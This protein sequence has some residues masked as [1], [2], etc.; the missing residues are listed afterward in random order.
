MKAIT[1]PSPISPLSMCRMSDENWISAM[2][3]YSRQRPRLPQD[4]HKGD[5]FTLATELVWEAQ[6]NKPRF[7]ALAIRMP[8]SLDS[9]YFDAILDGLAETHGTLSED[10]KANA[11]A[12]GALDT[13]TIL[14]VIRR[15][16]NLPGRPCGRAIGF[17]F[18]HLAERP[19]PDEAVDILTHYALK[20]PHPDEELW[21]TPASDGRPYYS[22]SPELAGLNCV[23]GGAADALSSLLFHKLGLW[24]NVRE[25]VEILVVDQ[26]LAVRAMVVECL[27]ARMN[28]DRDEAIQ[29]FLKL[30]EG[31]GAILGGHSIENFLHHAVF[32]HYSR[33]RTVLLEMVT[34]T[35]ENAR[36]TAGRQIAVAA[37]HNKQAEQDLE[38]ALAGDEHCRAAV[39][40]V[41]ATNFGHEAVRDVCRQRLLPF[42]DDESKKVQN[43][44]KMCFRSLSSE[45]LSEERNLINSFI[46][47]RAFRGGFDQL[48]FALEHSTALLPDV[49]CAIPERLIAQHLAE[50]PNEPLEQHYFVSSLPELVI[51]VYE[52]ARDPGI[53]TRCLN[54]IDAMIELGLSS[55]ESELEKVER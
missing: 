22:G 43:A 33:V 28:Q 2:V 54:V 45:Q 46:K 9:C 12:P 51:R 38:E 48:C 1:V 7:A 5:M 11:L 18:S 20:A 17:A 34:S 25:V 10:R 30:V 35:D 40:D 39:A 55:L 14:S 50:T 6:A 24:P 36:S 13:E 41:F 19:W 27:L 53:K 42:F 44:V 37:F 47:S 29:L 16:H 49:V 26:S 32:D 52:Q 4:W 3:R 15:L 8:E 31:A 23:R 21:K